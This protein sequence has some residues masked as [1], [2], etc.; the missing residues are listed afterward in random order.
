MSS[1]KPIINIVTRT[2]NRPIY[3]E[4]CQESIEIQTYPNSKIRKIV[5][6]DDEQDLDEYIQKKYTN[7]VVIETEREKRRKSITFSLS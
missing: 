3:F 1:D 6:F 2:S 4:R 7:L 5:T